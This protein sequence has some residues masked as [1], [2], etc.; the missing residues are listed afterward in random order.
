MVVAIMVEYQRNQLAE[1]QQETVMFPTYMDAPD[2]FPYPERDDQLTV[3]M[4]QKVNEDLYTVGED[5]N[6][7]HYDTE[8]A[9]AFGEA[10]PFFDVPEG[11]TVIQ[12]SAFL[13]EAIKHADGL[14]DHVSSEFRSPVFTGQEVRIERDGTAD[15]EEIAVYDAETDDLTSTHE[16]T[17]DP[18]HT[19]AQQDIPR[20][21]AA[22]AMKPPRAVGADDQ[23]NNLLLG[24]EADLGDGEG[25]DI[26]EHTLQEE[27]D[28]DRPYNRHDVF[29]YG[30][31]SQ[32]DVFLLEPG[33]DIEAEIDAA[34]SDDSSVEKQSPVEA[35]T[36]M[37]SG[38]MDA[39]TAAGKA[40]IETS[41]AMHPAVNSRGDG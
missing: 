7:I 23:L 4:D 34:Y 26:I 12:G 3:T 20:Y 38:M 21:N 25:A 10:A 27:V 18:D 35:W 11:E 6:P 24:I 19:I 14:V 15:G 30:D 41:M 17:Y 32:I 29:E 5:G 37:W 39:W 16:I 33:E 9:E 31:K 28:D 36:A 22:K 8:Y 1:G 40:S 2:L 13:Y